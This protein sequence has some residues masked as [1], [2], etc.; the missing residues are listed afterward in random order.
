MRQDATL[1]KLQVIGEAVKS[2]S[3]GTKLKQPQVP[4]PTGTM[5]LQSVPLNIAPA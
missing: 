2:L 3:E 1:R 5:G 4:W